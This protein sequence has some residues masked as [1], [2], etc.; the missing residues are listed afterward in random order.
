[1]GENF[2]ENLKRLDL[3]PVFPKKTFPKILVLQNQHIL[4]MKAENENLM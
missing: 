3:N 1:M 4:Y 2:N